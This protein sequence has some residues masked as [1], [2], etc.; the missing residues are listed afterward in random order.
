M[1]EEKYVLATGAEA[2]YRL[3]IVNDVHGPDSKEF[4]ERAGLERGASSGL[5]I[6]DIGCG[7]GKMALY[8]AKMNGPSGE[9]IGVD[10]SAGQ[11]EQARRLFEGVPEEN[12]H[13]AVASAYETG[14]ES[15]TFD[16]AYSRFLLMHI[17]RPQ[18]V[19]VE[20]ERILTPGGILA[21]EDGDFASP[22]CY[23]PSAAYD[24]C[25]ELYRLAGERQGAD[26]RIGP[27]LP[28][29]VLDAG[30]EIRSVA[31]AQPVFIGG[32]AKR[33]PEWTLEECAPAL[34]EANLTTRE[35]IATLTAELRQLA[36]DE[37]TQFGMARMTQIVAVKP[38]NQ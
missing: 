33:L 12:G 4:L 29:M 23:P 1:A 2:E 7:V 11:I 14:L 20:M 5:R 35:E 9:V 15:D 13:F 28:N 24:R 25:F 27:K 34:L 6:A 3:K 32:D 21:I 26:F 31:L 8:M 10:A 22:F 36:A 30:F 16:M 38:A 19:L 37:R 17:Q 18:D